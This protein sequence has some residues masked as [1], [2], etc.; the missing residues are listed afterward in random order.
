M[1]VFI[2]NYKNCHCIDL[3]GTREQPYN[4]ALINCLERMHSARLTFYRL[5]QHFPDALYNYRLGLISG[6]KGEASDCCVV[7]LCLMVQTKQYE[8]ITGAD[9]AS[10][11]GKNGYFPFHSI[12]DPTVLELKFRITWAIPLTTVL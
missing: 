5:F 8:Q 6:L 9:H 12:V 4:D 2:A 7:L 1:G 10:F 11:T 3:C